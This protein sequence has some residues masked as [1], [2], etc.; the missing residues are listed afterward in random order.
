MQRGLAAG[1]TIYAPAIILSSILEW[2]LD[3][4]IIITGLLVVIYTAS[5]GTKAVGV[6]Q[7]Q[8]NGRDHG[9]HVFSFLYFGSLHL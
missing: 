3:F 8:A 7:K 2:N 5:G 9:R 1:I 4:T 6:T